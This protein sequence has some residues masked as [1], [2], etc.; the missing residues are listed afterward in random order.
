MLLFSTTFSAS[1][2]RAPKC[3]RCWAAC[4][5]RWVTSRRWPPKWARS[6]NA[7]PRRSKGSITSV[8]AVYVPA[9]DLTDPAPATTFAHLDATI[10]L[11]R[12]IAEK[13]IYPAV[14]PLASTSHVLDPDIV[15][16]EHYNSRPR[17]AG[18]PPAL[19]GTAGHHRDSR[20]GRALRRGQAR[21]C[22]ARKS[23]G[24]SRSRSSS[25]KSSPA[26]G[27]YVRSPRPSVLQGNPR[28][29]ARRPAGARFYMKGGIDEVLEAAKA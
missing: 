8:Q 6:R 23:S 2:R 14:D 28:R 9:D 10:V 20:R 26:P 24:S 3:P 22:R 1:R 7:S 13:G 16:E 11:E 25:P 21:S 27:K 17:R 5:P 4:L 19:P 18:H 15:G 12:S 29:S